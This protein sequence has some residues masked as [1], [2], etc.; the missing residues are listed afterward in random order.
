MAEL[1]EALKSL[2]PEH[3]EDLPEKDALSTYLNSCFTAAELI[4]NSVPPA[5]HGT[6]FSASQPHLSTPNI[7]KSAKEMHASSVRPAPPH[8]DHEDLQ[9]HW[10]KPYK[11]SQ[12]DNPH[13]VALYKMAG[14]DRHGAWF[15]RHSVHEGIGFSKFKKAMAREL[16]ETLLTEGPPGAGA[17]RGLSAERRVEG[18]EIEGVGKME[19]YQLS[20]Q[21]P[22]PVS[23]RDFLTLLLSTDEA[24]SEKSVTE[25]PDAGTKPVPRHLMVVSRPLDHPD[26][27]P[28]SAFVRG[29]YESVE[30]V[31][32]IPLHAAKAKSTPNLLS[33][34]SATGGDAPTGRERGA[35]MGA[36]ESRSAENLGPQAP[37]SDETPLDPE[38]N[39]V[40]WIMVTRS[41]PAGGI[42]RFLV[43]RGTPDAMLGDVTKFLNWAT[44]QED[45][46]DADEDLE[47]QQKRSEEKEES[48]RRENE[49]G[50]PL[51]ANGVGTAET[52]AR[53]A[54]G[55]DLAPAQTQEGGVVSTLTTSVEAGV[56]A[57]APTS[58][59][60]FVQGQLHP[61]QQ[62]ESRGRDLSD[63]SSSTSRSSSVDS[64][65]SA[66][67][68]KRLSTAPEG[69]PR[70][71]QENVSMASAAS[72]GESSKIEKKNMS[73]HDKEILKIARQR[74]KLDQK[75]AKKREAETN[76]LKQSQ[77]KEESEQSKARERMEKE[78]RK[79]EERHR[80]EIEKL[81]HKR[82]REARK[83]EEKKR[84]K[85]DM[86]KL[87]FVARERDEWRS[88]ADL[89]KREADLLR[90]QVESLQRENTALVAR[91]GKLGGE[92]ALRG[93]REELGGG[94][95]RRAGTALSGDS[96]ASSGVG[97]VE[98][99]E[100]GGSS[101]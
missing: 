51:A 12:K 31:R 71:S 80:K 67:E 69:P 45:I 53:E 92:E 101:S 23:P 9:K 13:N 20:A 17:K 29:Q 78:M 24:L 79:T 88:Q 81:E 2:S 4:C 90:D 77:E 66:D 10:G 60:N 34:S 26:A 83:A 19:V 33:S 44:S 18:I 15:A 38:L 32:E 95:R 61:E 76:K 65:L 50:I 63:S 87:S 14:H 46:P 64:F 36:A 49:A 93:V 94:G 35:T 59:S 22:N 55:S 39:P 54:S 86:N 27:Q 16:P 68:M 48:I 6:P 98:K 1:H 40:E 43:D 52:S 96:L 100:G 75:L 11:F 56:A 57:Y 97:G 47:K 37:S 72:S 5:A 41:D 62:A 82:E 8:K 3:W 73:Q 28:R 30:L 84:K 7:A 25:L 58:V 70:E 99:K 85:E 21:M 42:P 89:S 91:V 74:E